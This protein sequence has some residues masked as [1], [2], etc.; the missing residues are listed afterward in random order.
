MGDIMPL[1]RDLKAPELM[2]LAAISLM[3]TDQRIVFTWEK[4]MMDYIL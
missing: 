2:E 3:G 4:Q 1:T